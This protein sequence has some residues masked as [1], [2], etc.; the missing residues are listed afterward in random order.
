MI[1]LWKKNRQIPF[2]TIFTITKGNSKFDQI[3]HILVELESDLHARQTAA[4]TYILLINDK[5][6]CICLITTIFNIQ[7]N[8]SVIF[9]IVYT[10]LLVANFYSLYSHVFIVKCPQNL[11]FFTC[12]LNPHQP[13]SVLSWCSIVVVINVQQTS[14]FAIQNNIASI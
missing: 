1:I 5:Q 11:F 13:K 6:I 14:M 12:F 10:L 7:S 3:F 8:S 4:R 2:I 9:C